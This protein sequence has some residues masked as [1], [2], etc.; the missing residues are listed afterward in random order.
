MFQTRCIQDISISISADKSELVVSP[1][2]ESLT[3]PEKMWLTEASFYFYLDRN[4]ARLKPMVELF[5]ST[6]LKA[7]HSPAA[8]RNSYD[9]MV[10]NLYQSLVDRL[11]QMS[12]I[13][14]KTGKL[15][16]VV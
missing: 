15:K 12:A 5:T 1:V 14:R 9:S 3:L 7:I 11:T 6:E 13:D 4:R 10:N 8:E 2:S 16:G